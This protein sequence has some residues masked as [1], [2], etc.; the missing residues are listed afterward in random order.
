MPR[1]HTEWLAFDCH[2]LADG[3]AASFSLM[4]EA[5]F[6]TSRGKNC[7]HDPLHKVFGLRNFI[8]Q[9]KTT[10]AGFFQ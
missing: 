1:S 6:R 5:D 7:F 10:K 2:D 8:L 9:K 3:S 4:A